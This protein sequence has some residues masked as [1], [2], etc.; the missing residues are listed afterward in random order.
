[1]VNMLQDFKNQSELSHP[2][3]SLS[4]EKPISNFK[5]APVSW[6]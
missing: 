5:E 1:M 3:C 6:F 2:A 4:N